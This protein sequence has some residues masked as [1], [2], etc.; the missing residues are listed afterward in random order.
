FLVSGVQHYIGTFWEV[1]DEVSRDYAVSFY[2][3]LVLGESIGASVRNARAFLISKYGEE[4]IIW[5]TY[6]LYGHPGFKYLKNDQE[7]PSVDE[8]PE[9]AAPDITEAYAEGAR[10]MPH[11]KKSNFMVGGSIAAAIIAAAVLTILFMRSA[12]GPVP[13]A[14]TAP[15]AV[16]A[17]APQ[18]KAADPAQ[19]IKAL[20]A[21][22]RQ[23]QQ[24]ITATPGPADL[25]T[26][27]PVS[28]SLIGVGFSGSMEES[29]AVSD[30]LSAS[31]MQR[32]HEKSSIELVEREKLDA[33]LSEL[34]LST[35]DI[36]DQDMA[37]IMLGRLVGA[38]LIGSG[39]IVKLG[40]T[41]TVNLRIFET[42]TSRIVISVDEDLDKKRPKSTAAALAREITKSIQKRYPIQGKIVKSTDEDIMLNIGSRQGV[43]EGMFFDII[44]GT[45]I[46]AANGKLLGY[47]Q[48]QIAKVKVDSVQEQ[49][50]RAK[51]R[52]SDKQVV[53]GMLAKIR[54]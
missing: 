24:V 23:Q 49:L 3:N 17:D 53:V 8:V 28:L 26:S 7:V 15:G 48:T 45:E 13:P 14:S 10:S 6:V 41:L 50:C 16:I 34:Q 27:K 19:V 2:Q 36:A 40:K 35:S 51:V 38:R 43:T 30:Q 12:P 5:A 33:I 29:A 11:E 31:L 22:Y 4:N 37:M 20:A 21:K 25:W 42:A 32:L 9:T 52:T 39:K 44:T 1:I 18:K 46:K 47:D 54:N